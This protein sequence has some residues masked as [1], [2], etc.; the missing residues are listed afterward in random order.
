MYRSFGFLTFR[1]FRVVWVSSL[2]AARAPGGSTVCSGDASFK[3]MLDWVSS[4]LFVA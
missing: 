2:L 1:D 3:V 4:F